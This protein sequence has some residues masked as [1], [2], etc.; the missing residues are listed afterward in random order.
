MKTV[1][2]PK[3]KNQKLKL[4]LNTL[5][6]VKILVQHQLDVVI[7]FSVYICCNRNNVCNNSQRENIK[8]DSVSFVRICYDQINQKKKEKNYMLG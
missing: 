2:K 4:K 7:M 3:P 8:Y 6:E 5:I 1:N